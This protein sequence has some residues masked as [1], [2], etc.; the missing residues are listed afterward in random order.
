VQKYRFSDVQAGEFFALGLT[1]SGEAVA[2]GH[3][4]GGE[5]GRGFVSNNECYCEPS[6]EIALTHVQAV[7]ANEL[8]ALV[9]RHDG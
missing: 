1:R 3:N 2:W 5:L 7:S 8:F 4:E 9:I 6:P